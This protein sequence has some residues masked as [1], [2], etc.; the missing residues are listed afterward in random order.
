M[1]TWSVAAVAFG[2]LLP[3]TSQDM[4][5]ELLR[6]RLGVSTGASRVQLPALAFSDRGLSLSIARGLKV[7]QA[8]SCRKVLESFRPGSLDLLH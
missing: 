4:P 2:L 6:D 5:A 7:P 3:L 8:T 1:V